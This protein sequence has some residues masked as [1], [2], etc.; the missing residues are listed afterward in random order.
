M[1]ILV[2]DDESSMLDAYRQVFESRIVESLGDKASALADDLFG[3][4]KD[5]SEAAPTPRLEF[6]VCYTSQG[7]RAV[8]MVD[9]ACRIGE[10]YKVVFIDIRMPP[11]IDGKETARQIRALDSEINL[12]IVT[13]YSDHSVTDIAATAGPPDK[14]FYISKPFAAEEVRQMA[15]ALCSRWDHDTG[16]VAL[17]R[18]KMSELAASEARANHAASHDFLTGAPNRLAFFTELTKLAA[19]DRSK[20]SLALLD[21]DRFKH[22]NDT[23]GHGAGDDLLRAVYELLCKAAPPETFVARMGGD[24]FGLILREGNQVKAEAICQDLTAACSRSFSIFGNSVRIGASCGLL[25]PAH[26]PSREIIEL[27]RCSDLALFQA[28]QDGRGTT[29]IF[30]DD[31]DATHRFRK[32][33]ENGLWNAIERDEIT[34]SYQPIVEHRSLEIVGFEALLRWNSSEHGLV[35]PN[36]FIPIAEE[37]Q[38]IDELGDLVVNRALRDSLN[39]PDLFVSINFSPR[40]FRRADFVEWLDSRAAQWGADPRRVQIEITE[41]AIFENAERAAE[42]LRVIEDRGYRIALDDFGT[43]YS[44]LFNIKNFALTCIK[45]DKSFIDGL[46][47]D[48]QSTAIVGAVIHLAN[49]LGLDVVA[50]GVEFE[51][52]SELLRTSGCSHL[53]GYLFGPARSATDTLATITASIPARQRSTSAIG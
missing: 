26:Y 9:E 29:R 1:K 22:V 4:D 15:V 33:I 37:S 28:K 14:I 18:Q 5:G 12:V 17:L 40:Q 31:M 50:E 24:E 46:G 52:Q 2:V 21:L 39:W 10:P 7:E 30:D 3:E 44:S 25:L 41:T 38:L 27:V 6:D 20:F 53:Q 32:E 35:S 48:R 51:A 34:V 13:A 45:I 11:G 23:F 16:Q 19:G 47:E 42:Q 43:G 36:I 8:A 49:S